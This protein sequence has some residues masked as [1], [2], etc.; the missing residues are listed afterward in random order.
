M[1]K[2]NITGFIIQLPNK[3]RELETFARLYVLLIY[4]AIQ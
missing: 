2:K 1:G 4:V 3:R